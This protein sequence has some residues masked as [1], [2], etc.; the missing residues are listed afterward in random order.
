MPVVSKKGYI[1]TVRE[2]DTLYSIARRLGSS[3]EAIERANHL[4]DPITDPGLIFPGN[5]LV[6]PSLSETGKVT[7]MVKS[8]DTVSGIAS[9][10]STFIDL[11]SGVNNLEN[12]N[13]ISVNQRLIVPVFIYEI[14]SG[15]TLSSISRRFGIP[16]SNITKANQGRPSSQGDLIWPEFHLILPLPTSRNIIVWTPLPGTRIVNN[17]RIE[18]QARAFEANVLHQLRDANG[19]IVSKERFTMA[20]EGAPEYGKFTSTLPFDRTPTSNTGELWVYTRSANDGSI[21]DL[22]KTKVYF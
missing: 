4:F 21:Q 19:T 2:G 3:V 17:Q 9:R 15:D 20:D 11:V 8:G 10:F 22:V 13:L 5:V 7:Y 14:Q 12:P 18:G 16:L 6:V 1:Y